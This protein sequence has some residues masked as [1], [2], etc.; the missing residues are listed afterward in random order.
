MCSMLIF[1]LIFEINELIYLILFLIMVSLM[2]LVVHSISKICIYTSVPNKNLYSSVE[3]PNRS[4]IDL[5]KSKVL[6]V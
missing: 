3:I 6:L 1:L 2:E 5:Y 4:L